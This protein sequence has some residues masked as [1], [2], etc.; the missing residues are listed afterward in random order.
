MKQEAVITESL[1]KIMNHQLEVIEQKDKTIADLQEK[2]DS[3]LIITLQK[4]T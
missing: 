4:T 2:L 1:I 3:I